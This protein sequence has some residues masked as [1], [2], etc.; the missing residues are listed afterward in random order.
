MQLREK[1]DRLIELVDLVVQVYHPGFAR[2]IQN[3][4]LILQ[5]FMEA[6]AQVQVMKKATK[7]ATRTLSAQSRSLMGQWRRKV[8]LESSVQLLDQARLI[9]SSAH[10]DKHLHPYINL[11][12]RSA[13]SSW[14]IISYVADQV[15]EAVKYPARIDEALESKDFTLAVDLLVNACYEL[16]HGNLARVM[17]LRKLR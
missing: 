1:E 13:I 16:T 6:T 17:A 15:V 2:S 3:F 8:S 10:N 4:S 11:I 12:S 9:S 7:E 14:L 5:L